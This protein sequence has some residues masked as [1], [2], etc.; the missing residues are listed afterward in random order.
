[1]AGAFLNSNQKHDEVNLIETQYL[2]TVI[3]S[4]HQII[5]YCYIKE[6]VVITMFKFDC[7]TF[8]LDFKST[9]M[10]MVLSFSNKT[11]HVTYVHIYVFT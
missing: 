4:M 2:A 5:S 7:I 11:V 3:Y 6:G 1:M 8:V 10:V 9:G